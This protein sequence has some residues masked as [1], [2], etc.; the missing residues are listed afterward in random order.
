MVAVK[1]IHVCSELHVIVGYMHA[2]Q[3][4]ESAAITAADFYLSLGHRH[5]INF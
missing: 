4:Q 5:V 2:P 3:I 1:Y